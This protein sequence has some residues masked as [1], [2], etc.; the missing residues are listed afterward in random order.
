MLENLFGSKTRV[1]LLRLFLH[2]PEQAYFVREL[3]RKVS[4]QINAVRNELE[5][6]V[7]MGIVSVATDIKPEPVGTGAMAQRK[8]YRLD[9][10]CLVYNELQALFAKDRMPIEQ[11]FVKRI[12]TIGNVAYL[13]LTGFFVGSTTAPTDMLIVGRIENDKVL[14]LIRNF[15]RELGREINFTILTPAEFRYRKE[16]TDRFLYS[17]LEEQKVVL[18]DNV[19]ERVPATL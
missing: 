15:E 2:N 19:N 13:A 14:P 3:T 5:H 9:R 17:I 12:S 11:D 1:K 7:A 18:I 4:S 16:I 6:L 10:T 8:Y